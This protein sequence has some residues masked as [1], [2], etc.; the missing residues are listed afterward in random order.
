MGKRRIIA[1]ISFILMVL[2]WGWLGDATVPKA[3]LLFGVTLIVALLAGSVQ[4][5]LRYGTGQV[6]SPTI[7]GS[8]IRDTVIKIPVAVKEKLEKTDLAPNPSSPDPT[9][10]YDVTYSHW[11]VFPVGSVANKGWN[12]YDIGG[13]GTVVVP[14]GTL[15]NIGRNAVLLA[16]PKPVQDIQLPPEVQELVHGLEDYGPPYHLARV[17]LN[18][19]IPLESQTM[20]IGKLEA[21]ADAASIQANTFRNA[22]M[23]KYDLIDKEVG[24]ILGA[25]GRVKPGIMERLKAAILGPEER[26]E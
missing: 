13:E 6:I 18:V 1:V 17:P 16:A 19:K 2:C 12:I 9:S 21:N 3:A 15:Y 25:A 10:S 24:R 22:L 11:L 5:E 26:R 23:G 7:K 8:Y 20:D 4:G 14:E